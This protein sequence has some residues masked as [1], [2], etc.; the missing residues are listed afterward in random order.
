MPLRVEPYHN[1]YYNNAGYPRVIYAWA[2]SARP[3]E[4]MH[5]MLASTAIV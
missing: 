1:L 3:W 2:N 4:A 5:K